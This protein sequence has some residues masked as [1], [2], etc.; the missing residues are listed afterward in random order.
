[1]TDAASAT[2]QGVAVVGVLTLQT[3]ILAAWA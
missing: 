2:G 3:V 1:M